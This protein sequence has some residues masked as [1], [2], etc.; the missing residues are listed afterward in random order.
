LIK[1][2]GNFMQPVAV[3]TNPVKEF[4]H[5]PKVKGALKIT[6]VALAAIAV[7]AGLVAL[8]VF[9]PLTAPLAGIALIVGSIALA[10]T[11]HRVK[12]ALR[13]VQPQ[14]LPPAQQAYQPQ[15]AARPLEDVQRIQLALRELVGIYERAIAMLIPNDRTL[16]VHEGMLGRV[17]ETMK[18]MWRI[19]FPQEDPTNVQMLEFAGQLD[20][21]NEIKE[22]FLA[23]EAIAGIRPQLEAQFAEFINN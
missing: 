7:F 16:G 2:N 5:N 4:F 12:K 23:T 20:R 21:F 13:P 14:V 17:S 11:V 9:F 22:R 1:N 15:P 3:R 18:Y 8:S 19:G 6:A 10:V